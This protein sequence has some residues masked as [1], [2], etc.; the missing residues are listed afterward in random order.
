MQDLLTDAR[1]P[2]VIFTLEDSK[3]AVAS[4]FVKSMVLTPDCAEIPHTDESIRGIFQFR[5]VSTPLIDLRTRL[6]MQSRL[7]EATEF[8]EMLSARE[9]DHKNWLHELEASVNERREFRLATDPHKCAFGRWYDSFVTTSFATR[10]LVEKFAE[11]HQKIHKIAAKVR[12]AVDDGNIE[13][14]KQIIEI[15]RQRELSELIRAFAEAK[16]HFQSTHRETTIVLERADKYL[17]IAVDTVLTVE[18]IRPFFDDNLQ[19]D[20]LNFD[21]NSV[22]HCLAKHG[23]SE[24]V[25]FVINHDRLIG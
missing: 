14:A 1:L 11:P 20:L 18:T 13:G 8:S 16:D 21:D 12:A 23:R 5:N 4:T 7:A 17:S 24:E 6:G 10:S 25:V 19:R 3:F 15:C 2:W 9:Q 22:I